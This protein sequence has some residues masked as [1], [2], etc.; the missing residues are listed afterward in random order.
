MVLIPQTLLEW[1]PE[2]AEVPASG[3]AR[4]SV[5]GR[6]GGWTP[7]TVEGQRL[8]GDQPGHDARPEPLTPPAA[9]PPARPAAQRQP[10]RQASAEQLAD[11]RGFAQP[12]PVTSGGAYGAMP[13]QPAA[14]GAADGWQPPGGHEFAAPP[15]GQGEPD[16]IDGL[17]RRVPQASLAQELFDEAEE[18][19]AGRM[20][21]WGQPSGAPRGFPWQAPAEPADSG[22]FAPAPAGRGARG[23]APQPGP[24]AARPGAP[25]PGAGRPEHVRSMMSAL[26]A[27]AARAR[28]GGVRSGNE[29]WRDRPAVRAWNFPGAA[30]ADPPPAP[31]HH[32]AS[33][34]PAP[35]RHKSR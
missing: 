33:P 13:V 3:P 22:A 12:Q 32:A 23:R 16:M 28:A 15:P 5:P 24:P 34:Y 27:G 19:A 11:P 4:A 9:Q 30:A 18:T 8:V 35:G 14:M 17:P 6:Q 1:A 25:A 10:Q 2:G 29:P 7:L 20:M 21:D 26:Q 31:S